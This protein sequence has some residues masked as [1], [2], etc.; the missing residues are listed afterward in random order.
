MILRNIVWNKYLLNKTC[1]AANIARQIVGMIIEE[2][3]SHLKQ[4]WQAS[5]EGPRILLMSNMTAV[6]TVELK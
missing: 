1:I 2:Q 5:L 3:N 6:H 4:V